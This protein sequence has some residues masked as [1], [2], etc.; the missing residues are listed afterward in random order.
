VIRVAIIGVTG[1]MGTAIVRAV[2]EHARSGAAASV[3]ASVARQERSF[4]ESGKG[5]DSASAATAGKERA[6]ESAGARGERGSDVVLV[7]G[8]ASSASAALGKDI[9]ELAGVGA[10]GI[11]VTSDLAAALAQCDVAIDFSSPTATAANV[12]AC[13]AARKPV[14]IGTT[15]LS[16]D[17]VRAIETAS[18]TTAVLVAPNTS[19][20]I[21]LL[22]E[23]VRA[24]AKSLPTD[25]DIEIAEA[26]HRNKRDAPSGTALALGKAAAQGRGQDFDKVAVRARTGE[27]P[28]REGEIGFAV[29]RGGDIVGDHTVVFASTG[30]QLVLGHRATDRGIFARGALEAA[31]WLA[32]RPAG[33]YAM[34]DV[35]GYKTET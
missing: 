22:I 26:H 11:P 33:R 19:V 7:A 32:G 15:G 1:R 3:R 34:R 13:A 2:Q 10:L 6:S 23:L 14:L 9:G 28:R 4:V 31:A 35:V 29:T 16:S 18:Q 20:G 25:F 30:E 12:A 21:T 17:A 5:R 24:A 27:S 8:V